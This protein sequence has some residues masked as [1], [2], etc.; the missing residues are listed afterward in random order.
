MGICLFNGIK[1]VI[2][3]N[4]QG[5]EQLLL[6]AIELGDKEAEKFLKIIKGD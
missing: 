3:V 6:K 5:S 1:G 2:P 4:K